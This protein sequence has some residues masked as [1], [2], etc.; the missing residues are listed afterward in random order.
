MNPHYV[1]II[2]SPSRNRYYVGCS[3]DIYQRIED[4]NNSRSNYTRKTNDWVLKW[5][6]PFSSKEEALSEE[7][8]IKKK[9]SRK[10][11]EYLINSDS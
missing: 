10:Y 3:Q 1:Y 7:R 4:H 5:Q 11:I 2:F 8:R 9:K 6:K